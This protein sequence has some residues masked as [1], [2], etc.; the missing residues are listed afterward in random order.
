MNG[1]IRLKPWFGYN[2][3]IEHHPL[4]FSPVVSKE[5]SSESLVERETFTVCWF[6]DWQETAEVK[7]TR[8]HR[9]THTHTNKEYI[10]QCVPKDVALQGLGL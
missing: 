3:T 2:D 7:Q 9:H 8:T 1:E 4:K 5:K 6:Q 10:S